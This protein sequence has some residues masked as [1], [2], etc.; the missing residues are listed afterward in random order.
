VAEHGPA[1]ATPAQVALAWVAQQ[2]GV[3]TVIPGARSAAQA[4]ANASA[5]DL[6][7]LSQE[8]LEGIGR[9]YDERIRASVHHRW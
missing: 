9:L 8:L 4:R 6:P 7:A 3:S 5:A 1:G 2:P